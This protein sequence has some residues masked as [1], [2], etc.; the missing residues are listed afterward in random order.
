MAAAWRSR[1]L[2][3][4]VDSDAA[5]LFVDGGEE[6]YDFILRVL[7]EEMEGRLGGV[8]A[9]GPA[10]EDAVGRRCSDDLRQC[11]PSPYLKY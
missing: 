2:A 9:S 5:E 6:G 10:E 3:G 8:F 7:A 4:A 11:T 1:L